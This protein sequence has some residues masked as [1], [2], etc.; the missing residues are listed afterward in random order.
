MVR[1]ILLPLSSRRDESTPR[2]RGILATARS[3]LMSGRCGHGR[4]LS[5]LIQQP[6]LTVDSNSSNPLLPE[7]RPHHTSEH[8]RIAAL[9]SL[10]QE[11]ESSRLSSIDTDNPPSHFPTDGSDK[12]LSQPLTQPPDVLAPPTLSPLLSPPHNMSPPSIQS[13]EYIPPSYSDYPPEPSVPAEQY[14]AI[15]LMLSAVWKIENPREYQIKAIFYL[16]FLRIRML[17]LIRKTGEGKSLV[18]LGAATM[19]CGV[20][21]CLVPL[22]GLGSSQASRL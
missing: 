13:S 4:P 2:Q 10:H 11:L 18:L 5:S 6:P 12:E 1:T 8:H 7:R 19:L 9:D 21:I 22:L 15:L 20:T 17:Y 14:N 16:V 3:I